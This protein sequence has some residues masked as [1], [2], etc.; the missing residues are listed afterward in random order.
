MQ[1]F[2]KLLKYRDY[3]VY[4]TE[5]EFLRIKHGEYR[6]DA[7][8]TYSNIVKH[9]YLQNE[10]RWAFDIAL[11][12]IRNFTDSEITFI[13]EHKE[14][15]DYHFYYGMHVRNKYVH[16]SRFHAYLMA[17]DVSSLV[18]DYLIGIVCEDV[19]PFFKD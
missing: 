1:E 18:Y 17:D 14:I 16:P 3:Y 15:L 7:I 12:C 13:Q 4:S 6:E 10:E 8:N 5:H 9:L 11:D 19:N 2:H